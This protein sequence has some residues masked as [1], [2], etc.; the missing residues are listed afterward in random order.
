MSYLQRLPRIHF[1][2]F[3]VRGFPGDSDGTEYLKSIARLLSSLIFCLMSSGNIF[4]FLV[5]NKIWRM[6]PY[7]AI[8]KGCILFNE[9]N[10]RSERVEPSNNT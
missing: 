2:I 10:P 5:L 8:C 1:R 6:A 9:Y 4:A 3:E 7:V